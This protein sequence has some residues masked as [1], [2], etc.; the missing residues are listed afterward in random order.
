MIGRVVISRPQLALI[1]RHAL[2]VQPQECCG[3]LLGREARGVVRVD[4]SVPAVNQRRDRRSDR[5]R[6]SPRLLLG[7]Q[8]RARAD[9]LEMVGCY[10]SHPMGD[11]RPSLV[12]RADAWPGLSY[13]IVA[14]A[15]GEVGETRSWRLAGGGSSF[16]EEAVEVLEPDDGERPAEVA[17]WR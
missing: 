15:G 17:P 1:Y 8:K 14:L 7:L 5:Y 10:H 9:N 16:G 2:R 3:V 6:V 11:P 13:L 12:D 4:R